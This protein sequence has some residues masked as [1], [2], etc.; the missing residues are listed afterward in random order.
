MI[1]TTDEFNEENNEA[2]IKEQ[3]KTSSTGKPPTTKVTK[4]DKSSGAKKS[5]TRESSKSKSAVASKHVKVNTCILPFVLVGC[6]C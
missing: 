5:S 3:V 4:S 1:L 6:L 2:E